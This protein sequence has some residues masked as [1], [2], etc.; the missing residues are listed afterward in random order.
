[1]LILF[2]FGAFLFLE[3]YLLAFPLLGDLLHS[4]PQFFITST[5]GICALR[6]GAKYLPST[7][8]S[9]VTNTTDETLG[10]GAPTMI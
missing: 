4:G 3:A 8:L 6:H 7:Q 1:M 2:V 10:E 9:N 5:S